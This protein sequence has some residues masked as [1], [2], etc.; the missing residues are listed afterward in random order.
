MAAPGKRGDCAR[1]KVK[2]FPTYIIINSQQHA[3]TLDPFWM[4]VYFSEC[5]T[6]RDV[7]TKIVS[8]LNMRSNK[9]KFIKKLAQNSFQNLPKNVC[10]VSYLNYNDFQNKNIT[11]LTQNNSTDTPVAL[12]SLEESSSNFVNLKPNI[13]FES[14]QISIDGCLLPS[15]ELSE[16]LKDDD[17][18]SVKVK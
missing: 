4:M 5:P 7:K 16:I 3:F 14:C 6:I 2:I 15:S 11:A 1:L 10:D 13:L 9:I 8:R 17:L 12:S 18:V